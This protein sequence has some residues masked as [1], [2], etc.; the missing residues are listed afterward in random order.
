MYIFEVDGCDN[1]HVNAIRRVLLSEIPVLVC[2]R[3]DIQ[4]ATNTSRFPN[5]VIAERFCA[6]LPHTVN[7]DHVGFTAKLHVIN[8]TAS[9]IFVTTDNVVV[10]SPAGAKTPG[11]YPPWEYRTPEGTPAF[12]PSQQR[13]NMARR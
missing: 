13:K 9:P 5:E 8:R 12:S 7:P 6:F 2:K 3:A 1:V 4:I 10:E 11:I